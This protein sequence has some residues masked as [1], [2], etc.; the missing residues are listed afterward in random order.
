MRCKDS[1]IIFSRTTEPH[2]EKTGILLMRK[3]RR[4][5]VP[6]Q[7]ISAFIFAR[8][9]EQLLF[10]LNTKF[11]ASS[12]L[13]C[14]YRLICVRPGRKPQRPIFSRR[15]TRSGVDEK[16]VYDAF[17]QIEK[18]NRTRF[19]AHYGSLYFIVLCSQNRLLI[20]SNGLKCD[21]GRQ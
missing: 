6:A 19:K 18:V 8:Q 12:S 13:L 17:F 3:Q 20:C 14:L 4:C 1:F 16:F 11:Q 2:Y 15:S 21:A 9:T 5:A 7:L 10:F